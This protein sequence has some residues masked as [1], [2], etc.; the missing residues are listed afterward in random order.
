MRPSLSPDITF[1]ER[2]FVQLAA[3]AVTELHLSEG[4]AIT[5]VHDILLSSMRSISITSDID[6]WLY[7]ALTSAAHRLAE[8]RT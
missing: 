5:L 7:G 1:Y 6:T 8:V 2:H 3:I 4:E